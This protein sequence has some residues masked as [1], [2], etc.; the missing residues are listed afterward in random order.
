MRLESGLNLHGLQKQRGEGEMK[1]EIT[2]RVWS[3]EGV[4]LIIFNVGNEV[5]KY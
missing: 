4:V 5:S 2:E 3:Y 1:E